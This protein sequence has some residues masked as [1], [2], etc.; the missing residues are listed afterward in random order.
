MMLIRIFPIFIDQ[1]G[2][3][4]STFYPQGSFDQ[5]LGRLTSYGSRGIVEDA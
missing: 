3:G 2:T 4:C 5:I 1:R